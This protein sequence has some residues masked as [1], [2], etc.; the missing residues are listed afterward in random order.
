MEGT[1][2]F[3]KRR[4]ASTVNEITETEANVEEVQESDMKQ[5]KLSIVVSLEL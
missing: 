2:H 1:T 4:S 3:E 5:L